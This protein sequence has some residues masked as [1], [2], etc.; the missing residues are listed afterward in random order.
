MNPFT[1]VRR[2]AFRIRNIQARELFW[3]AI[4][5]GAMAW[6][7]LAN[8]PL[9]AALAIP[10]EIGATIAIV[11]PHLRDQGEGSPNDSETDSG[12]VDD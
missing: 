10:V 3:G 4:L 1:R 11:W 9:L 8:D 5:V 2:L 12:S 6:F 7:V